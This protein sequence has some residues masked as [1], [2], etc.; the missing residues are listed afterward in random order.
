MS[1]RQSTVTNMPGLDEARKAFERYIGQQFEW[2]EPEKK[3]ALRKQEA[4]DRY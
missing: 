1:G 2:P 3:K 4:H